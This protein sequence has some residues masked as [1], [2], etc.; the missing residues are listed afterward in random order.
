MKVRKAGCVLI[1]RENRKIA[2]VHR[3]KKDDYSFPKGHWEDGETLQQCAVRETEE[4][5]GRKNH[6]IYEKEISILKYITSSGEDVENYMYL[7]QDDGES[8]K[9]FPQELK[10]ELVWVDV[11][12]V[13]EI[14]SYPDLKE[15]W[16]KIKSEVENILDNE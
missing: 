14:L 11:K 4:E 2:L 10:E 8:E 9:V 13:E 7:A 3:I 12:D 16:R 6:L 15:F 1:N 5:T